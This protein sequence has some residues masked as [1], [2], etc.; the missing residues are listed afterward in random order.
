MSKIGKRIIKVPEGVAVEVKDGVIAV[1]GK[2]A[3]TTLNILPGITAELKDGA[4]SF[5]SDEK[6]K[7]SRSN[8][9]T[10]N[11]L[12]KNAITGATSNFTKELSIVG[13]GF[14]AAVEGET[15]ILNLGFSHPV[16]F[17]IP[18]SI[19][20]TVEKGNITIAGAD[21]WLVGETAANIRN[22]RT[23]EPYQG[24]GI[25]YKDEVVRKKAGK[26]AAAGAGAAAAK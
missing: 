11:A 15:L 21:K 23:P 20:I 9:G 17:T 5:A 13:I 12:A 16:R 3:S 22:F 2:N 8:W 1:K 25:R 7:Q 19:K 6:S 14:K 26:K 10:M 18:K 4:L 24:K